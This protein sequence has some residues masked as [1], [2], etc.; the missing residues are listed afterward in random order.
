MSESEIAKAFDGAE[1]IEDAAPEPDRAPPAPE[2]EDLEPYRAGATCPRNDYGNGQRLVIYNPGDLLYVPR[3]GWH[4]WDETQWAGDEDEIDIRRRAQKIAAEIEREIWVLPMTDEEREELETL[5]ALEAQYRAMVNAGTADSK[6]AKDLAAQ[7]SGSEIKKTLA[8]R[9]QQHRRWAQTSGNSNKIKCMIE[10][11]VPACAVPVD[12]M[13]RDP[14]MLNC[15][16]GTLRF[17]K[18]EDGRW[19]L[20]RLDHDRAH[21]ITKKCPVEYD[22]AAT[23]P[24]WDAFLA[25][26]QPEPEIRA[27]LQRWFGY[28]I[29]GLTSEQKMAFLYGGGRNGKSTLVEAIANILATY[30]TTVP[31]E[32]FTGDATRK[33]SDATPDLVRLPGARF[34]RTSEPEQGQKL[35]EALVKQLTGG[36]P[37]PIRRMHKEFI[38]VMPEFKLTMSGNHRP[39]IRGGDDGIWRRVLLV[40]FTVQVPADKVDPD[41]PGKLWRERAGILNWLLDGCLAYLEDGLGVPDAVKA[42]TEEYRRDSDKVLDFLE[43]EVELTGDETD[44]VASKHLADVFNAWLY[45]RGDRLWTRKT[46]GD[47]FTEKT[48]GGYRDAE[49][50]TFSKGKRSLMGFKGLRIRET[51]IQRLE[52][53]RLEVEAAMSRRT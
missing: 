22:P 45:E 9:R 31:I 6:K 19:T 37:I 44:W 52:D 21:R 3:L 20:E 25:Q 17:F 14:Y 7:I 10:E 50:R 27:F 35:K 18:G 47:R 26:V 38:D 32:T 49:G 43:L 4:V 34:V 1:D 8:S 48:A 13:N 12:A 11:A 15:E 33:G 53:N 30:G 42:A 46:V 23:A 36:E 29:T 51:A 41:L 39:D 16:N 24:A 2:P 5:K 28:S 40:P